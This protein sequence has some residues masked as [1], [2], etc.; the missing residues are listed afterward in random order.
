MREIHGG[1][2]WLVKDPNEILDFSSNTNP[3]GPPQLITEALKEAL[4][5]GYHRY[6]PEITYRELKKSIVEFANEFYKVEA[7]DKHVEV[8]NGATEGLYK[9]FE[10]LRPKR[11]L[12][13]KPSYSTYWYLAQIYSE[14]IINFNYTFKDNI[15]TIDYNKLIELVESF[16]KIKNN[17][18]ILCNPNNPTGT[19]IDQRIIK[20]ILRINAHGFV[21]IDESFIDFTNYASTLRLLRDYENLIIVKSFTKIFATPGLRLGVCFAKP[22]LIEK[23]SYIAPSWRI[24]TLTMYAYTKLLSNIDYVKEYIKRTQEFIA[25]ER[26]LVKQGLMK[27]KVKIYDSETHFMLIQLN[28]KIK[29][30]KLK[31]KLLKEYKILIRDASTIPGL[32]KDFIRVSLGKHKYN[33]ILIKSLECVLK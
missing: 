4:E 13:L 26:P 18:I 28:H 2:V 14:G 15:I 31:E 12:L 23:L 10:L 29:S 32:N 5:R 16:S 30:D 1:D 6:Y 3:L 24:G 27:L 20:A 22:Q 9:V 19:V 8:F 25:K 11:T 21:L 17:L 7:L 33:L